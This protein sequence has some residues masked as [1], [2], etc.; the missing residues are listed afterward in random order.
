MWLSLWVSREYPDAKL[1][2]LE[3][4]GID[5]APRVSGFR[6][7]VIQG[8]RDYRGTFVP[9]GIYCEKFP[10]ISK[11]IIW[12]Y[13]TNGTPYETEYPQGFDE[14]VDLEEWVKLVQALTFEEMLKA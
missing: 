1:E 2:L 3:S 14:C 11:R 10:R 12:E 9:T 8:Y 4:Y 5:D 13:F 6:L 7:G